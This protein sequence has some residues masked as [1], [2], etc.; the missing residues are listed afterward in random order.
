MGLK[1]PGSVEQGRKICLWIGPFD[2]DSLPVDVVQ[3]IC[4]QRWCG[5]PDNKRLSF[6]NRPLAFRRRTTTSAPVN[7]NVAAPLD[8][9][10]RRAIRALILFVIRIKAADSPKLLK[11]YIAAIRPERRVQFGDFRI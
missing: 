4:G 11:L 8:Y 3:D 2:F 10:I 1:A 9:R 7:G 5:A 6:L